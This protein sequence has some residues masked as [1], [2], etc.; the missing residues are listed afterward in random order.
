MSVCFR[1]P[2]F[3][4]FCTSTLAWTVVSTT[5]QSEQKIEFNRDIR[6]VLSDNCFACHGPDKNKRKSGLRLDDPE[7]PFQ[8]S[9]SGDIAI[10]RGEPDKSELINRLFT[11]DTDELMPPPESHKTLS[12]AQKELLKK[13]IA[14]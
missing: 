5:A 2:F 10:V 3:R 13:W 7:Q 1:R 4:V 9:K 14:Q 11:E 6:P 8:P 12:A